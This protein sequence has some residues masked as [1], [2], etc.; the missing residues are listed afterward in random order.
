MMELTQ[1]NLIFPPHITQEISGEDTHPQGKQ[2]HIG[3]N[4]QE[5]I[6]VAYKESPCSQ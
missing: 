2:Y 6:N 4:G 3:S 1:T 5:A